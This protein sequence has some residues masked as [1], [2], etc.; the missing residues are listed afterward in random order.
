MK[1]NFTWL[2][3]NLL[4]FG[5][6]SFFSDAS[7]EMVPLVLPTLLGTL[8]SAQKAPQ[9]LGLISGFSTAAASL[10]TLLSGWIS[11]FI[12]NRKPLILFG[13]IVATLFVGILGFAH[14]WLTVFVLLTLAW[15]G[16]GIVRAPRDSL[17]ADSVDPAYYGHAFGFRQALDTAGAVIG[18]SIVYLF[19]SYTPA[20]L[21]S[22][23][24]IPG[25][26]ALCALAL[27]VQE[28]PHRKVNAS[29]GFKLN[30][31]PMQFYYFLLVFFIFG[32]GKFNRTLLLLRIQDL[33]QTTHSHAASL[34]IITLL[35][36]FRNIIQVLSA[37]F[38]GAISDKIGRRIPLA[39]CGYGFFGIMS[40]VLLYPS[41]N[42]AF[43]IPL[44]FLSGFSAGAYMSLQKSVA[45]DVLPEKQRGTGYGI[46]QT[47]D[48][49]SELIASVVVGFL[50]SSFTPEIGFIYAAVL[51][52]IAAC[53]LFVKNS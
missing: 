5:I 43:L 2:N 23:T 24:F 42:F 30:H 32:I 18:P 3:R 34:S 38:T 12:Q 36:I 29:R 39:V 50:W 27:L 10:T 20:A 9:Y 14:S 22:I 45:A 11:D 7:H 31:L 46:L 49:I 53:M 1:K 33:L 37:Y 8:V 52:F 21:F 51:S 6:A 28:V 15:I 40:L 44:F 4:G 48:S 47:A 13:Y 16:R 17:L 26:L 25:T 41:S 35:Y 19:S